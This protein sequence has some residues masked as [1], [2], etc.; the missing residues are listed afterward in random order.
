MTATI[1]PFSYQGQQLRVFTEDDGTLTFI[2]ADV[3]T[4]L[5]HRMA[6]DMTRAIDP[7]ERGTRLVS[8]PSGDQE[9]TTITEA[10]L[11]QAILQRQTGRMVDDAQRA[12]VKAFQRWVTHEVLPAIRRTGSYAM[13]D[14]QREHRTNAAIF[15]A[16]ALMELC[17]A[18]KGLIH[19]DHL[20]AKARTILARGMGEHAEIESGRRPLYTQDYLR[21]K[22]L[23]DSKL[24]SVAG[25]FGKRVKAAYT[26]LH[27]A[28]PEKYPL[29]VGN[30]QVRQVLAYTE[31]DRSLMDRVW[32][33]HYDPQGVLA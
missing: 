21:E 27:G 1:A 10:G 32:H 12:A 14:E 18:A 17:Q 5:G 8:T 29:T 3:A 30:G 23:S 31:A 11:Y 16:R 13:T 33:E 22:G 15:Q 19:P 24:R 6:S 7:D 20:E 9:M 4:A 2:A 28:P 25:V 26:D